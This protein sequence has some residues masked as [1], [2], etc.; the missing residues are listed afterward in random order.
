[1]IF[2]SWQIQPGDYMDSLTSISG[3]DSI[4]IIRLENYPTYFPL[5]TIWICEGD[6]YDFYG[7]ILTT[8]GVYYSTFQSIHGCDSIVELPL[9]V[10]PE[11]MVSLDPFV[12]DSV[13]VDASVITL[14]NGN[15]PGG[16]YSGAGVT[17]Q[18]FD[19]SITGIGEFW[20]TYAYTDTITNCTGQDSTS[21]IV[22]DPIGINESVICPVKL[23][24]NP[25][26]DKFTITGSDLR[27][28]EIHN[29]SG[30]LIRKL[31]T[32]NRTRL[33][34]N[35]SG[36]AKGVYFIRIVNSEE[37]ITKLLILM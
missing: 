13:E 14:P 22:Y 6:S 19:P 32:K 4:V 35:L 16:E 11:P 28:V 23:F 17:T 5:D 33:D 15:P 31:D 34:F 8:S 29:I 7:Q 25:G 3:S 21:I 2:G 1:M 30:E 10:I 37:E 27:L 36:Q 24:P 18:G 26:T 9:N 12:Q 20:I